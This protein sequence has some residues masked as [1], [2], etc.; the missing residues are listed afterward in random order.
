MRTLAPLAWAEW[1]HHPWRTGAALLAIVLGV[2]L[3][4]AVHVINASALGEFDA[5]VRAVNGTPDFELRAPAGGLDETLYAR[6]ALDPDVA[7]ASPIVE[8]ETA[9]LDARDARVP[10]HVL[11][12]DALVVAGIAPALLPRVTSGG[13]T[14]TLL[15][16]QAVFLNAQAARRLD[17]SE[18]AHELRLLTP[19]GSARWRIA[20][21]VDA[22]GPALAVIDIAGVQAAFGRTGRLTRIDVRLV[23]GA[24]RAAVL[25]R[26]AL[27]GSV[28]VAD[29]AEATERTDAMSRAYRVNLAV[30]ALV[31][32]FT[33]SFLVYAVLALSVAQRQPQLALLGVLGLAA[34]ERMAFVLAESAVLGTMGAVL[35]LL[36][37]TGL[38]D[39][40]LHELG[41]DLGG[42]AFTGI[43]PALQVDPLAAASYALLGVGA[44]V[45]GGWWPARAAARLAP[46]QAL[47]G[48]GTEGTPRLPA[49]LGPLLLVVA[50]PLA[51]I[52]AIAELPLAAYAA[53]AC[54]LLG[55]IATLPLALETVLR[56]W[57][58]PRAALALVALERV[59]H[60]PQLATVTVAGIVASLAL[61]VAL[62]VMVGSFR[63]S[64]QHWLD[65]VLPADL[66]V[67][68]SGASGRD[69]TT[70]DPELVER[71]A[72]LPGVAR[73]E[74]LRVTSVELDPARP[75]VAVVARPLDDPRARLP[76]T[77]E[78]LP[79][80]PGQVA[81]YASEALA[82]LYGARAGTTLALPLPDGTE[83]HAYVRGTWRDYARQH[84][85][86]AIDRHDWER[87]AHDARA[88]DL[89]LW[90]APATGAGDVRQAVQALARSHGLDPA[91]MEFA[92]PGVIRR[93]SLRIFD[94]SFAVTVWLEAVAIG[95]GL[96][97]IGASL[98]AQVLARRKEFGLLAHLGFTRAQ[99]RG[100]VVAEC[101]V[102]AAVGAAVGVLLGLAVG[103]VLVDVVN[104]Q[105]FHWTMD[106]TVP[107]ERVG[108]LVLAVLTAGAFTGW[109][110][111]RGASARNVV[112]AVKEDW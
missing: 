85:A 90:L 81:V 34:R 27:P 110:S 8:V 45:L 82:D 23:P 39:L 28:R 99:V 97:G 83:A 46:A 111:A 70:F 102:A 62:M 12:I 17:D 79:V 100:V 41:G 7:V 19:A 88:S 5:A 89:A 57:P 30:L 50:V 53:V 98:S 25:R 106:L 68:A 11:G 55:G 42:G 112:L 92:E 52:P 105:S 1:R 15:D 54:L 59:R 37:G 76:L 84:G 32:L 3:G 2:A 109:A 38:A 26:L 48:L 74:P 72:A 95:I 6:V 108:L 63:T 33:G 93:A 96:F 49:W 104:P 67:R 10:L 61:S 64:M 16:P 60:A 9:A 22:P 107:W 56:R 18:H 78:L 87:L 65:V 43:A 14:R 66:Y 20:G 69:A 31:A 94:R 58:R 44:A 71:I 36:L 103:V 47:K 75:P 86:L 51:R 35:G 24:D 73:V 77:G 101:A 91:A 4:H 40:A 21:T 13:D 29:A 80:R